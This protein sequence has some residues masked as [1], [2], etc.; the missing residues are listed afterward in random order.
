MKKF[1]KIICLA[2]AI[3]MVAAL[4]LVAAK[5]YQ[6]YTY[7][8]DGTALHSPDA[9]TP[10]LTVDYKYMGLSKDL[11]APTD[12]ELDENNNVYIADPKTNRIICLDPYYK[13][14]DK[15][16]TAPDSPPVS[17]DGKNYGYIS[18]FTNE[19]GVSDSL[20]QPYGVF[21]TKDKIVNGENVEGLIYVCD[22]G[23]NRIVVFEKNGTFVKIIGQPESNLFDEGA[24]Y[25]P[26]AVAVDDYDRL[27]VVSE[28][29]IE[30]IIVMTSEGQ[31][32]KFIGAQKVATSAWQIL[33]R[34]FQ[35]EEQR[36]KTET[37]E[38]SEYNNITITNDGFIYVTTDS[39]DANK[40]QSAIK[41]RSKSGDY[42]PVKFLN[43][44]G[45]EI[46]RRNGFYPPSGEVQIQTGALAAYS[47]PSAI[48]DV[49]CGPSQTWSIID[50]L[51]QKVFTYDFDGN[52]LFAFGDKGDQMGNLQ[53]VAAV[54]YQDEKMILLDQK[55]N[56]FTI[57]ARTDYG[58]I[59]VEALDYQNARQYDLAEKAW[60][61]VLKRNSN[62]DAAYIG[63][64]QAM[65][66]S[67]DF[68]GSLDL[69]KSAY[70]TEN[71]SLSYKELRKEWIGNWIILIPVFIIILCVILALF[72][73]HAGKINKA[74]SLKTGRKSFKEELYYVV[75]I[76]THPFDGFWDLKHEKR[77]SVRASIV[78]I[79]VTILAYYYKAIGQGYL[80]NQ[81]QSTSS[82]MTWVIS[83]LMTIF[84]W[85]VGNWC[86]TTLFDG[87]GSFKDIFIAVSYSL[88]PIPLTIIP[89]TIISN[90]VIKSEVEILSFVEILGLI[91]MCGLVIIG[92]MVTHDYPMG[93]NIVTVGGT[94]IAM[95]FIMFV[96]VL[97]S[98][99]L[100]KMVSFV[101]NIVVELR[102]RM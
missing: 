86:L 49:A 65:Y 101:S 92:M 36:A 87:E 64:G 25:Q 23:K 93:K 14:R 42:A 56:S 41:S 16:S 32:T 27:F 26:V 47:G 97:F 4:P 77:G 7:S 29:T 12:L 58:D 15:Q 61:E 74:A 83:V 24:I 79:A 5:P 78:F 28:S 33:M 81:R 73:K 76:M 90:F 45:E 9:Y 88:L 1:I 94:I 30:G 89:T 37:S 75:H 21:V 100:M 34:R 96:A 55:S 84:L 72:L 99:L 2:F 8:I 70:D 48:I 62:F 68:E 57:F 40:Q 82:I 13:V 95:V 17:S 66:R 38:A 46:M 51:R 59:L 3:L 43:A 71:Y 35:T 11:N 85:S 91:Y 102:Y 10:L 54:A 67:G 52:L 69:F 31:F 60:W 44:S 6:T 53:G 98:T 39:L 20:D 63:I 19:Y 50:G 18:A 80:L 22:T